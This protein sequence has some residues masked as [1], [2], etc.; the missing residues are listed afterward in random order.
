MTFVEF[1]D[2]LEKRLGR[3]ELEAARIKRDIATMKLLQTQLE[4]ERGD[5][6]RI[7]PEK[8]HVENRRLS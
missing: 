5:P 7:D 6:R 3:L 2:A 4:T 1:L 8:Y